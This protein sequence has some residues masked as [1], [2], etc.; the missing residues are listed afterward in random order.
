[1]PQPENYQM[2]EL[3]LSDLDPRTFSLLSQWAANHGRT[4]EEEAS[5]VLQRAA[6]QL[7]REAWEEAKRIRER[8]AASG[9]QFS[10]SAELIR[11]G[12][13]DRQI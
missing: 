9:R 8:L 13:E 6:Q 7:S 12:R 3:V 11:E 1:M 10:D 5:V 4:V 2:S